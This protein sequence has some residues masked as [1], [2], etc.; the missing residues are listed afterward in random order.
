M[1]CWLQVLAKV[2]SAA[3]VPA[4]ASAQTLSA[5]TVATFTQDVEN[6]V[7]PRILHHPDSIP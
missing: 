6:Q 3:E 2:T 5:Y 4:V 1:V 7:L